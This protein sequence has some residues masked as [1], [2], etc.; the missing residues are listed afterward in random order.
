MLGLELSLKQG[1]VKQNK[2]PC[3]KGG[4]R[5]CWIVDLRVGPFVVLADVANPS[6]FSGL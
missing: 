4:L 2:Q 5:G 6:D 1:G 3:Y